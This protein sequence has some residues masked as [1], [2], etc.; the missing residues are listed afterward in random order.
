M[1]PAAPLQSPVYRQSMQF[2][3]RLRHVVAPSVPVCPAL[4]CCCA[5]SAPAPASTSSV[6]VSLGARCIDKLSGCV[7][8]H[9]CVHRMFDRWMG[10]NAPAVG[11]AGPQSQCNY[12]L[13]QVN[14]RFHK[15][16][17]CRHAGGCKG[18]ELPSQQQHLCE[19]E[20]NRAAYHPLAGHA[21][22]QDAI[23][24]MCV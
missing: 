1:G 2:Q 15:G 24:L 7:A 13:C 22:A 18:A 19:A 9:A 6:M 20:S 16:I 8:R 3:R 5:R 10:C 12:Q 21:P 4:H 23:A 14:T 17:C 11:R